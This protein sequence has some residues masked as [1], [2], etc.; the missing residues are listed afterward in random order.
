MCRPAAGF[1]RGPLGCPWA[2]VPGPAL[3]GLTE[4]LARR[5]AERSVADRRAGYA[6]EMQR[7]VDATLALIERTGNLNPSLREVLAACGLSTQ[8]FYRYFRSKDELLLALLDD[9][10]RSLVEYLEHRMDRVEDPA[11]KVGEWIRGVMAQAGDPVAAGRTRPFAAGEDRIAERF[12]A[13]HRAS[14]ERL[15]GLL[16]EPLG[17]MAGAGARR[18]RPADV[19]RDAMAVYDLTFAALRRHL[20]EGEVPTPATVDHLVAF[21]LAGA[22]AGTAALPSAQPARARRSAQSAQ[23]AQPARAGQGSGSDD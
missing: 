11:G 13:E 15:A 7:I 10:R 12:P 6:R 3:G 23:P 8:A 19:E 1:L 2:V 20:I 21:A 16:V 4:E 22:A 9:G 18:R 17:A 5:A 14:V